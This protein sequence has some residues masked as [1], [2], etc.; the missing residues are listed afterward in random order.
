GDA[1]DLEHLLRP[2]GDDADRV[3]DLVVLLARGVR[4]DR[5]LVR[6]DRPR[7]A[8]EGERVEVLV[9]VRVDAEGKR[10]RAVAG[11]DLAVASDEIGVIADAAGRLGHAGKSADLRQ[12]GCGERGRQK[13]VVVLPERTL[14]RDDRVRVLVHGREDRAE[15]GLDRVRE[16]VG[17]ADHRDAEHDRDCGEDRPQ[18][19][20]EQAL[21]RDEGHD[22]SVL[23]TA[24]TSSVLAPASSLTMSPSAMNKMRSAMT[25]ARASW[26]TMTIVCP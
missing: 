18:L 6:A 14:G 3:A 8:D 2:A 15:R 4:V 5:H 17:A 16:N 26:V 1:R 10:R 9:A 25:A 7:A 13:V 12:Q 11:D 22:V 20:P 21:Q 19:A 23:I 24:S